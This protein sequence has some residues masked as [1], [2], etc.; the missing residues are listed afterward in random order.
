M[1]KILAVILA[2]AILLGSFPAIA[3]DEAIAAQEKVSQ[4]AEFGV[5]IFDGKNPEDYVSRIELCQALYELEG[6]PDMSRYTFSV[7]A[8]VEGEC[9]AA[10][11]YMFITGVVNGFG[12]GKFCPYDNLRNM[13]AI[14]MLVFYLGYKMDILGRGGYPDGCFSIAEQLEL[15]PDDMDMNAPVTYSQLL[16]MLYKALDTPTLV[17]GCFGPPQYGPTIREKLQER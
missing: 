11:D 5:S 9:I 6:S 16:E 13:D 10:I 8:D 2:L 12:N 17:L 3:E 14:K 7:F 1:R 15:L 4:L